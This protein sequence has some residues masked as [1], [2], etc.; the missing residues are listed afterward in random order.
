MPGNEY[1]GRGINTVHGFKYVRRAVGKLQREPE[2]F[3]YLSLIR[4]YNR[5]QATAGPMTL[6]GYS[7]PPQ[8]T[9]LMAL[10]FN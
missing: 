10:T 6:Q 8:T 4:V 5:S 3:I 1:V 7:P 2:L 9:M